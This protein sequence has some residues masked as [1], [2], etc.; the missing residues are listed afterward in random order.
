MNNITIIKLLPFPPNYLCYE[1]SNKNNSR[2]ERRDFFFSKKTIVMGEE[3]IAK[4]RTGHSSK[5]GQKEQGVEEWDW[6]RA[7]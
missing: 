2:Q 4:E 7:H 6:Q 5:Q 1:L 3:D